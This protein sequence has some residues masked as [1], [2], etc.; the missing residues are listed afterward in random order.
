MGLNNSVYKSCVYNYRSFVVVN[1]GELFIRKPRV[2]FIIF[3][4]VK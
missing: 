1:V 2:V 3:Y 4:S